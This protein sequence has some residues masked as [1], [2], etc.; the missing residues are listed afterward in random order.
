[1]PFGMKNAPSTLQRAMDYLLQ[2]LAAVSIYLDDIL[3]FTEHWGQ[4]LLQLQEVLTRLQRAKLT[5]KLAKTTFS[6]TTV[7]YLGHEVGQGHVR[8]KMANVSAIMEYPAPTTRKALRRFLGM[9]DYYRRFCPNLAA[10][11]IPLT[12]L[13]SVAVT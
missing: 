13:T 6:T 3:I 9:A 10:A 8:S 2:D 7:T 1:M 12:R 5:I 4:H 11:T